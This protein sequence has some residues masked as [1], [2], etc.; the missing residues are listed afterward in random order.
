MRVAY[1]YMVWYTPSLVLIHPHKQP[2]LE[3]RHWTLSSRRRFPHCV[4]IPRSGLS[5]SGGMR[6]RICTRSSADMS[7]RSMAFTPAACC[8]A[9]R[10]LPR[11]PGASEHQAASEQASGHPGLSAQ[12]R[13]RPARPPAAARLQPRAPRLSRRHRPHGPDRAAPR[14]RRGLEL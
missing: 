1:V 4:D 9:E 8:R 13:V 14:R 5:H 11:A 7:K 6:E 2:A 10:Y 3:H 12:R